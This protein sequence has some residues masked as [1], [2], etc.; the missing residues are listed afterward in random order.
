MIFEH[1]LKI[2]CF[3]SLLVKKKI[4]FMPVLMYH[5]GVLNQGVKYPKCKKVYHKVVV[6]QWICLLRYL[7]ILYWNLAPFKLNIKPIA[8][9]IFE[10][11]GFFHNL[12]S[13]QCCPFVYISVAEWLMF[14]S[15]LPKDSQ[16][17]STGYVFR[18]HSYHW[19]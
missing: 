10:W 18:T 6:I 12:C 16:I 13:S 7:L 9:T 4:F 5:E 19:L 14:S 15:H 3:K 2:S 11:S 17:K 8:T 1:F